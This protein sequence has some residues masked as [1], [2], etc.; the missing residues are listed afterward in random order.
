[1]VLVD[2]RTG[3]AQT[4][5]IEMCFRDWAKVSPSPLSSV[6]TIGLEREGKLITGHTERL[7]CARQRIRIPLNRRLYSIGKYGQ[8]LM[9]TDVLWRQPP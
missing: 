3:L 2:T 5:V 1:M 7:A 8:D 4:T 9:S 6:G